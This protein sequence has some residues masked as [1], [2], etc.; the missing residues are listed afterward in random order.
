MQNDQSKP[1]RPK[2]ITLDIPTKKVFPREIAEYFLEHHERRN[3]IEKIADFVVGTTLAVLVL[4]IIISIMLGM[5][6]HENRD[7]LVASIGVGVLC[8]IGI[9][10]SIY[11]YKGR[12]DFKECDD[13]HYG[14]ISFYKQ[15]HRE[16][17]AYTEA[18]KESGRDWISNYEYREI[19]L[20]VDAKKREQE[21]IE[22]AKRLNDARI[23]AFE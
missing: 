13:Y 22:N 19:E 5:V 4:D 7:Y 21:Q 9:A 1:N 20:F 15:E 2:K 6:F 10:W 14:K 12:Y 23:K 16:I 3:S 17:S 11:I 18:I 8:L